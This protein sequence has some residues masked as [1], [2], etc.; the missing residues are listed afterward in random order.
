MPENLCGLVPNAMLTAERSEIGEIVNAYESITNHQL[1]LETF[2]QWPS[3]HDGEVRRV[4]LDRMRRHTNGQFYPSIELFVRGW[5]MTSEITDGG[6]YKTKHDTV[7]HFLFEEVTDLEL[8]GLNHQ[9]VVSSLNFEVVQEKEA[10]SPWLFVELGHCFGLS[11]GFKA[12]RSSVVSVSRY[13][14][15]AI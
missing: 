1:V 5:I 10:D 3:F 12:R 6:Y 14:E 11:G 15:T 13:G 8:D 4:V 9:N 7:V 2:G